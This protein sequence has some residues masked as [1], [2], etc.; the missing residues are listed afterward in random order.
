M[1]ARPAFRWLAVL[2]V[3]VTAALSLSACSSG[4][5]STATGTTNIPTS[6]PLPTGI[7]TLSVGPNVPASEIARAMSAQLKA[8]TAFKIY[9]TTTRTVKASTGSTTTTTTI[10]MHY[11][12]TGSSGTIT[13]DKLV[14]DFI[15]VG[16]DNYVKAPDAFWQAQL[17]GT[18][19]SRLS[20][21]HD[22]WVKNPSVGA[23][24]LK[25]LPYTQKEPL[26]ESLSSNKATPT[27]LRGPNKTIGGVETAA[28]IDH[29]N[30]RT[31]YVA[32]TGKFYLIEADTVKGGG[33]TKADFT[34]WDQSFTV[35]APPPQDVYVFA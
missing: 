5:G 6:D 27:Y 16:V 7:P 10:S 22:K 2:A 23:E 17:T 1:V 8:A 20:L 24:V 35:S 19:A 33:K 28:V 25:L 3:A 34:D 15:R 9:S 13:I 12:Q 11:G 30:D 21:V 14:I 4:S 26:M 29:A 32:T 31:L 18:L